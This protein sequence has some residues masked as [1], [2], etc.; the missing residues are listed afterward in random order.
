LG[1]LLPTLA[2]MDFQWAAFGSPFMPGHLMVENPALRNAHHE[3]FF[4]AT[5]LSADAAG[6]L[7][8]NLGYGLFPLTP[9]L[10]FALPGFVILLRDRKQRAGAVTAASLVVLTCLAI[11]SM[12]NWRGGWTLGPRYLAAAVPFLGY[13][14][15]VGLGALHKRFARV[16]AALA[17]GATLA[18]FVAS[19]LPSVYY[20]H[21][22]EPIT[23]PLPHLFR[24]LIA[25]DFAPYCAA[26][27]IGWYGTSSMLPL[28]ALALGAIAWILWRNIPLRWDRARVGLGATIVAGAL[29]APL[30]FGPRPDWTAMREVARVT[31][32]WTPEGHDRAAR[33]L[34]RIRSSPSPS[35]D[36][37]QRLVEVY[38]EEGRLPNGTIPR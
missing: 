5:G 6:G 4:G 25:H 11:F 35:A 20:P 28:L 18:A 9:I 22:P 31:S 34:D 1:G 13:A 3:G 8:F 15:V 37:R 30:W 26:N 36:A 29:L 16:T 7:L 23:L 24:I 33:L 10:I 2:M 17:L 27:L 32:N 21:I 14:S 12:N 38:R 19:G